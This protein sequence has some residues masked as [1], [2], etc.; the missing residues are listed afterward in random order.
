MKLGK[1]GFAILFI[2]AVTMPLVKAEMDASPVSLTL[3]AYQN[4][5]V[6]I[7]EQFKADHM[8][9]RVAIDLHGDEFLGIHVKDDEGN[10]LDIQVMGQ[11]A[12]IDSIGV[13]TFRVTYFS[14]GLVKTSSNVAS[15]SVTSRTPTSIVLPLG[16]DFFDMSD[17]P[18]R[19]DVLGGQTYLEFASG[20]IYVYYLV[21]LPKLNQES[22]A[23]IKSAEA[24]MVVKSS[25]GYAME[26]ALG[27][28]EEATTL[29]ESGEYLES[30]KCA[31]DALKLAVN[32]VVYAD[33]AR[34][35]IFEAEAAIGSITSTSTN[36]A[37]MELAAENI[38][39]AK[40]YFDS[41]SY[42]EASALASKA[43][44]QIQSITELRIFIVNRQFIETGAVLSI[45]TGVIFVS[46]NKKL[47][48][49]L[50]SNAIKGAE[51]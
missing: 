11:T 42:R 20:E 41:G 10:P 23:S 31:D 47:H 26:G 16:A 51:T 22:L 30:K 29:F 34:D 19:I 35:Y 21:G 46:I 28:L 8:E 45:I 43:I 1:T 24:Y 7:E 39:H 3:T 14:N 17:L 44:L 9:L 37:D 25:Q 36:L 32:T 12:L 4:D 48:M 15:I 40:A 49:G 5:L 50:F 13:T 27:I 6:K 38:A 33:S 18:I 2:L